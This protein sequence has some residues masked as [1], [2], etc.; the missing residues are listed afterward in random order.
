M[1][2]AAARCFC[3]TKI[4]ECLQHAGCHAQ[5]CHDIMKNL[6]CAPTYQKACLAPLGLD[7]DIHGIDVYNLPPEKMEMPETP[8]EQAMPWG[9]FGNCGAFRNAMQS[10]STKFLW[11][12]WEGHTKLLGSLWE[13]HTKLLGGGARANDRAA[14][15]IPP[16]PGTQCG[17]CDPVR[18]RPSA[19]GERQGP[20]CQGRQHNIINVH[21]THH[22]CGEAY[23]CTFQRSPYTLFHQTS[24]PQ[25]C[26]QT[27]HLECEVHWGS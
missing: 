20:P 19:G 26:V 7:F 22:S 14:R 24:G 1:A 21:T 12:L 17:L 6:V 3:A 9:A 2:P 13:G 10:P 27:D 25:Q 23:E 18:A 4:V 11:S 16:C 5:A 15:L 8:V